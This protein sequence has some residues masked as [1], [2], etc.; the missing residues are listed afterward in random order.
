MIGA[1]VADLAPSTR[2]S[3]PR[4]FWASV[5]AAVFCIPIVWTL[6]SVV[7]LE[8]SPTVSAP[9]D[10]TAPVSGLSVALTRAN[11]LSYMWSGATSPARVWIAMGA[12]ALL[13]LIGA[14]VFPMAE[15]GDAPG[16]RRR[17][18][19]ASAAAA[20]CF[21]TAFS[22][23]YSVIVPPMEGADESTHLASYAALVGRPDLLR[24]AQEWASVG[25]LWRIARYRKE[26]FR[27]TDIDRPSTIRNSFPVLPTMARSSLTAQLW[28]SLAPFQSNM[29][30]RRVFLTIRLSHVLVFGSAV[31][32]ATALLVCLTSVR[33]P[34]LLSFPLLVVPALPFFGMHLGESALVA[35]VSVIFAAVLVILF[36]DGENVHW[37][38]VPL[39]ITSAAFLVG[40]RNALPMLLMVATV[41]FSRALL[42]SHATRQPRWKAW[43]FWGGFGIA[44]T[45]VVLGLS[46]SHL[47]RLL[48]PAGARPLSFRVAFSWLTREWVPMAAAVAGC[49]TELGVA[50]LRNGVGP[51]LTLRLTA[52]TRILPR[53]LAM[54]VV[55]SLIGSLWWR[56]PGVEDVVFPNPPPLRN[57]LLQVA[58]S[59][60][61]LFRLRHMDFM[62]S[63]SFWS[64]FGWLDTVP[65]PL[66]V[67]ALVGLSSLSLICLLLHI[68]RHDEVRRLLWLTS[69]LCGAVVTLLLY[70][71]SA[72]YADV[73]VHGRYLI[74]WYLW[75]IA[76]FWTF[77]ALAPSGLLSRL[78]A[79]SGISRPAPFV[80]LWLAIHSY[81]LSAI[82]RR[83]F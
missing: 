71:V 79:S 24:D 67:P 27:P 69:L 12:I 40:A 21:A 83:Y 14:L 53:V 32:L 70:A 44:A 59:A 10:S 26:K 25:H 18:A 46:Q 82:L 80:A 63:T 61:T 30:V 60:A 58:A 66:F 52:I 75:A 34:Q 48:S 51:S 5:A 19:V 11:L 33:Y 47:D 78:L 38:G 17:F 57:Y 81:S 28:T 76:V 42:S 31:A 8:S 2:I 29:S 56:Y 65:S 50:R 77:P 73:N 68:A 3:W 62:L 4:V 36:L 7:E 43:V 45:A 16:A 37:T 13:V 20:F 74:G 1:V 15:L 49:L 55:V 35:S 41:L 39:G 9:S 23:G 22:L 6:A 54:A 72:Y 64:G